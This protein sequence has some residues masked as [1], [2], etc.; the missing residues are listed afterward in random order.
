[1]NYDKSIFSIEFIT[2]PYLFFPCLTNLI[3]NMRSIKN[4]EQGQWNKLE[5]KGVKE[6]DIRC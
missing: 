6:R 4:D 3:H 2:Q 5:A 1:V